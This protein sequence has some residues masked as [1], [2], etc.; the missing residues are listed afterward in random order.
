M[1]WNPPYVLQAFHCFTSQLHVSQLVP[2][3][4]LHAVH[5]PVYREG[6]SGIAPND[7][8]HPYDTSGT[9]I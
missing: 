2:W 7:F 1:E 4:E 5:V 8:T 3:E 6:V 9:S